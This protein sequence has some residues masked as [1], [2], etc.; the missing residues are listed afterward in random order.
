MKKK[1]EMKE[2]QDKQQYIENCKELIE[3]IGRKQIRTECEISLQSLNYWLTH[4]I[5]PAWLKFLSQT[6]KEAAKQVFQGRV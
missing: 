1:I 5:P 6:H 4:G 3:L 2:K